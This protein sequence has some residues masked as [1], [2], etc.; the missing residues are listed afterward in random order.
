MVSFNISFLPSL[1]CLAKWSLDEIATQTTFNKDRNQP[2]LVE[3]PAT[4]LIKFPL[5]FRFSPAC[6]PLA[7]F[8]TKGG[9]M[10]REWNDSS[11]T[12]RISV[13]RILIYI[14]PLHLRRLVYT[15][16]SIKGPNFMYKI[17][18]LFVHLDFEYSRIIHSNGISFSPSCFLLFVSFVSKLI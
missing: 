13:N 2:W 11:A 16:K 12:N 5:A 18:F 6:A 4:F 1:L 3:S 10:T 9:K 14:L 8:H 7:D 17:Y 15:V